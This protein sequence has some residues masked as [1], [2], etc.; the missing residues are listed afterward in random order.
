M[1]YFFIYIFSHVTS[2]IIISGYWSL[3]ASYQR[4]QISKISN[5]DI[6]SIVLFSRKCRLHFIISTK[7]HEVIN[8][9]VTYILFDNLLTIA[10]RSIVRMT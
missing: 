5:I 8:S 7:S 9:V 4:L 6:L 3:T 10:L 2:V 1:Q